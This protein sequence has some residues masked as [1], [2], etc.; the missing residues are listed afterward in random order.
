[1]MM[2]L[3]CPPAAINGQHELTIFERKNLLLLLKE[4]KKEGRKEDN[5]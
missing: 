3:A 2:R 1:M 4:R 5:T